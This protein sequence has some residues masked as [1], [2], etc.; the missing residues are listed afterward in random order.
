MLLPQTEQVA[1]TPRFSL[2][3]TAPEAVVLILDEVPIWQPVLESRQPNGVQRPAPICSANRLK[4]PIP[5]LT[6]PYLTAADLSVPD[7]TIS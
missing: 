2:R 1:G 5:N 7:R 4:N 3:L 6:V